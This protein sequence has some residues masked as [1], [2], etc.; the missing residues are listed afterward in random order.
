VLLGYV[1]PL[2]K[3]SVSVV[4]LLV[5]FFTLGL[6]FSCFR[7]CRGVVSPSRADGNCH[8]MFRNVICV[9]QRGEVF[10]P[11]RRWVVEDIHDS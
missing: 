11:C 10:S 1:S 4:S 3:N 7:H 5:K 9:L 8:H 6:I 2:I